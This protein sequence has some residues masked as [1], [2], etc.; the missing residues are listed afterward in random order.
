M[1][2]K[3]SL[4]LIAGTVVVIFAF[5]IAP[6]LLA[7]EGQPDPLA[8]KQGLLS[9]LS[10]GCL[11]AG[12]CE[13]CDIVVV[14]NNVIKIILGLTGSLALVAFAIGGFWI[15]VSEGDSTKVQKGMKVFKSAGIGIALVFFS[16]T[17]VNFVLNVLISSGSTAEFKF[18]D[19]LFTNQW[20]TVCT[21][22]TDST[23]TTQGQ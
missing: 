3:S 15:V 8:G 13:L 23:G 20:S 7:A 18:T 22:A 4:K 14:A 19:N 11:T 5:L 10:A 2:K 12:D 1:N 9:N 17:I 21:K 6:M 16:Y